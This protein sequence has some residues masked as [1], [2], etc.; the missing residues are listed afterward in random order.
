MKI[1]Y[2]T[3]IGSTIGFFADL[4]KKFLDDGHTVD[5][6]TNESFSKIPEYCNGLDFR[7]YNID[8]SRNPLSKS[9]LSVIKRLKQIVNENNYDIVHCH[10]PIAAAL[11]RIACRK[12]RK[13]GT[14][15]FYT[16]HGFHFYK[17]APLKNWLIYYPIEKICSYM[18][19]VLITINREDYQRACKKMKAKRI[20]YVKGVGIDVA[21]FRDFEFEDCEKEKYR[22]ELGVPKDAK[23]LVSV[24]ELNQNKN[25]QVVLNAISL[26]KDK[27]IHYAVAGVGKNEENLLSLASELEITD[28][29]HL[30]GYRND[31]E[32]LYKIADICCFPS[33]REGL[34]L[35]AVEGMASGLPLVVADNRGTRD[36]CKNGLNGFVCNPNSPEEFAEAITK[37]LNNNS[38]AEKMKQA[39]IEKSAEFDVN[40]INENMLKIY[41]II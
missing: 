29:F 40:I 6:A 3:T 22:E 19:D 16:A 34:G 8:C 26:I 32:K 36:F 7:V 20:E 23:L 9:N 5:I 21:K 30:L 2:V 39:N 15:V 24:G 10:T 25:H 12:V 41:G 35:A 18:T 17:G 31:I 1:L 4:I 11:T 28:R 14:K 38:L 33:I 37:I 27:N 13:N